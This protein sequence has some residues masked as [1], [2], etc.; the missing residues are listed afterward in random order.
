MEMMM[1]RKLVP[2]DLNDP[3]VYVEPPLEELIKEFYYKISPTNSHDR[4]LELFKTYFQE[5]E[6]FMHKYNKE[7]GK[8]S[9]KALLELYHLCRKRRKEILSEYQGGKR[10]I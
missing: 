7:A 8:R 6:K 9:R 3:K 10:D 5:N 1:P 2:V 4:M